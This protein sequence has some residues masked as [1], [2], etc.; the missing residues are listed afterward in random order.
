MLL[1][2]LDRPGGVETL[3]LDAILPS[4]KKPQCIE[5][6]RKCV[7]DASWPIERVDKLRMHAALAS[8]K[9][10][11]PDL[12]LDQLRAMTKALNPRDAAFAKVTQLLKEIHELPETG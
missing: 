12:E 7:V 3:L 4:I 6:F 11:K 1:P 9:R 8:L 10:D 5:D 2:W